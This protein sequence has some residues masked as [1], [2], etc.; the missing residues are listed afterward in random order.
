MSGEIVERDVAGRGPPTQGER[1]H[2]GCARSPAVAH[3]RGQRPVAPRHQPVGLAVDTERL[4]GRPPRGGRPRRVPRRIPA[5][6]VRRH[7]AASRP[8]AGIRARRTDPADGQT[9]RSTR[10]DDPNRHASPPGPA[11]RTARND[12]GVR[13]RFDPRGHVPL[14][15]GGGD[16]AT[17]GS[18]RR[19]P[20]DRPRPSPTP[21]IE[22]TDEFFH[23]TTSLR[24][25]LSAGMDR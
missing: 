2:P 23:I 6:V 5:R 16:V 4:G 25:A 24:S 8:G 7:A 18:G 12:R 19:R 13:H 15:S 1:A 20:H 9:V 22:D 14:R 17:P 10:R 3:R 21:D 11:A